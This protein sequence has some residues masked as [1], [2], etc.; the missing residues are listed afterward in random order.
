MNSLLT[1]ISSEKL[2]KKKLFSNQISPFNSSNRSFLPKI[3]DPA[4][5]FANEG[6][7]ILTLHQERDNYIGQ[8]SVYRPDNFKIPG[9]K[10]S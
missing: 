3:E 8:I 4:G 10:I 2:L 9:P 1:G 7:G 5:P 6:M